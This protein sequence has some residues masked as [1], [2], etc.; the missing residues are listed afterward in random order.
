MPNP[1]IVV[2]GMS[3]FLAIQS[4]FLAR[5]AHTQEAP[6]TTREDAAIAAIQKLG[7]ATL[8]EVKQ[9]GPQRYEV[10]VEGA[11]TPST[12]DVLAR[13]TQTAAGAEHKHAG[14]QMAGEF[15]AQ[16]R[17]TLG[18]GNG[19]EMRV[20]LSDGVSTR[21]STFVKDPQ[22]KG[23]SIRIEGSDVV[24]DLDQ[25]GNVQRV[26]GILQSCDEGMLT[27][28]TQQLSKDQVRQ[29]VIDRFSQTMKDSLPR[30]K[31]DGD[32]LA[33]AEKL[34]SPTAP[35]VV[36]TIQFARFTLRV[37]AVT[38]NYTETPKGSCF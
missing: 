6:P 29:K 7:Q 17:D 26:E 2:A 31:P 19:E 38:G 13:Y 30:I 33:G 35:Y 23:G 21:F 27:A 9:L 28:L 22:D 3:V 24:V 10:H 18:L 5:P 16:L 11:F 32:I 15:V 1:K 36:Y 37:D 25:A 8:L 12:P 4:G 14:E 34:V 20:M